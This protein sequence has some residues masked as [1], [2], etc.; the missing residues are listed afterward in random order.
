MLSLPF[1]TELCLYPSD[2]GDITGTISAQF[3]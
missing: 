2:Q 3:V 1:E